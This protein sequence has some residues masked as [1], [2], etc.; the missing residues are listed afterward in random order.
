MAGHFARWTLNQSKA[1]VHRLPPRLVDNTAGMT[2]KR[3]Q[4]Y[5][6]SRSLL[7]EMMWQIYGIIQLPDITLTCHGR[8]CFADPS[9]PDFNISYAGNTVGVLLT[10]EGRPVGL[11]ME[12]VRAHSRQTLEHYFRVLSASEKAWINVQNDISEACSQI[13]TMRQSILKMSGEGN[14]GHETLRLH[15][16]S[17]RLRS[18]TLTHVQVLCDVESLMVWSCALSSDIDRLR[19]WEYRDNAEWH[20]LQDITTHSLNMAPHTLRLNSLPAGKS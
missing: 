2:E 15:P 13:W 4:R 8:P 12:I 16:A 6:A 9:L 3:R 20:A 1:P 11:D 7:A 14:S 17:G 19:L 5:L 10:E 18:S